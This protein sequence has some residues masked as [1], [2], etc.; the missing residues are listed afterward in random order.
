VSVSDA[1]QLARRD[2]FL[3]VDGARLEYSWIGPAADVAPTLV[4]L[5]E[6]LGCVALW[7]EFPLEL[8][9]ATGCGVLTYSRAGYGASDPVALP[10]EVD[11]MHAEGLTVLPQLLDL[12][13]VE[14]AILVGHSDGGS[15]ALIHAGSGDAGQRLLGL[16]LL[17]PHVFNEQV[18]VDSIRAAGE[19]YAST[20]LRARLARYQ[21]SNVDVAFRGWNDIWLHPDFWHWNIEAY[22]PN[23]AV[24]VL[25]IQGDDD[26]Y[27]SPAQ[28]QAIAAQ[29]PGTV[30]VLPLPACHHS[31][32]RDQP[33]ATLDAIAGFVTRLRASAVASAELAAG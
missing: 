15:I 21:G 4:L 19:A 7:K 17:S 12:A 9:R 10:R 13:G 16:A 23:V 33:A 24:P 3:R 20:D 31:P 22:L 6:G 28:Y 2:G 32:H 18:C 25:V 14:Q 30:E 8:A 27:G 29:V 26:E 11:Y 5:H 1:T